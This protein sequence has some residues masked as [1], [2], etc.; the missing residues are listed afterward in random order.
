[1]TDE[2]NGGA[3]VE[4]K[5]QNRWRYFGRSLWPWRVDTKGRSLFLRHVET[6]KADDPFFESNEFREESPKSRDRRKALDA[7]LAAKAAKASTPKKRGP[8]KPRKPKPDSQDFA[9][10]TESGGKIG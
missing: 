9:A 6:R 10:N 2:A 4:K 7:K 1:V 8:Y 5:T 3:A